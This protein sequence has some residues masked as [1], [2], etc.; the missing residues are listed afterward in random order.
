MPLF[1]T[2]DMD[3]PSEAPVVMI[4]LILRFQDVVSK[5]L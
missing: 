4:L 5:L 2:G 1:N 3:M